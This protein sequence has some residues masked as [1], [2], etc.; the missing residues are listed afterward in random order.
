M[1]WNHQLVEL[2]VAGLQAA[3]DP[4]GEAWAALAHDLRWAAP[5]HREPT[6]L[7]WPLHL[8]Q[9]VGEYIVPVK[10]IEEIEATENEEDPEIAL[11]DQSNEE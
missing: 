5:H 2:A 11:R 3:D 10:L 7:P 8:A 6:V 4:D 9:L 1:V